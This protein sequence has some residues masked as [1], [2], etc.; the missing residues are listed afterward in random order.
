MLF[1]ECPL[2]VF[3][4]PPSPFAQPLPHD[5][6]VCEGFE[7][8]RVL[9]ADD[10]TVVYEA[11]CKASNEVV[12][13]RILRRE[14]VGGGEG[15]LRIER[16]AQL[17][18]SFQG[19]NVL[20]TRG[21]VATQDGLPC[22]VTERTRGGSLESL[23]QERGKLEPLE[24]VQYAL[25]ICAALDS[26]HTAGVVHGNLEASH[27]FVSEEHGN[28]VLKVANFGRV[29]ARDALAANRAGFT[30]PAGPLKYSAPEQSRAD[31]ADVRS[32]LWSVGVLLFRMISGS[33]PYPERGQAPLSAAIS[34]REAPSLVATM[35]FVD[36]LLASVVKN[37]LRR[38]PN[39]RYQ[40]VEELVFAL[41]PFVDGTE[42]LDED[43]MYPSVRLPASYYA[44]GAA[45]AV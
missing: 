2:A 37:L 13:L 7:F 6:P 43:I 9:E 25:Q 28:V 12:S 31:H 4:I 18:A 16:E 5:A 44:E 36:R 41:T 22:L 1:D 8:L 30:V 40:D 45:S 15:S 27:I 23:L 20:A 29:A 10:V 35:P 24:A 21:I 14:C 39:L 32:D 19:P 33:Y 17:A 38:D 11:R 26:A 42:V 3:T 34:A